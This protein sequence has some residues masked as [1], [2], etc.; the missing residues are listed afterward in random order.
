MIALQAVATRGVVS[1]LNPP[2]ISPVGNA[3]TI[4]KALAPFPNSGVKAGVYAAASTGNIPDYTEPSCRGA[5]I[6]SGNYGAAIVASG[7]RGVPVVGGLLSTVLGGITAHHAAAVKQEQGI[8]CAE[9]PGMQSFLRGVD[10]AVSQGADLNAAVQAMESAYS[11]FVSRTQPIFKSCNAA[12]DY[13]KYVR[14]AIEY[15]KLNYSLRVASQHSS[16][17]GVI[18]GAV[19]AVSSAVSSVASVFTGGTPPQALPISTGQPVGGIGG[20]DYSGG[21]AYSVASPVPV[22][23]ILQQ[24]GLSPVLLVGGLLLSVVVLS[25]ILGR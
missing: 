8:L 21:V 23:S 1:N 17:Q 16:A 13:R 14:A 25:K 12:C 3:D 6:Q 10:V 9:V 18:G 2:V 7:L 4:T 11:L 24:G 19:A 5:G 20:G 22:S 15:R